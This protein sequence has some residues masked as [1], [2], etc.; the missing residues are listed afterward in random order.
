M[1]LA[2][3]LLAAVAALT[4]VASAATA[5]PHLLAD[6]TGTWE[7]TVES[8]GGPQQVTMTATQKADSV[9]GSMTSPIGTAS[10][11]GVVKGD[12]VTFSFQLD[13]DGQL[14]LI[15]GAGALKDPN[16]INGVLDVSGMGAMPFNAVRRP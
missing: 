7:L 15:K 8:P 13:M 16:T 10:F 9:S 11:A 6:L 3:R 1:S 14:L 12:S 4:V 5:A 2:R